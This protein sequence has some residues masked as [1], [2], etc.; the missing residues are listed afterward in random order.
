[1]SADQVAED[2]VLNHHRYLQ[3]QHAYGCKAVG[4]PVRPLTDE[5]EEAPW[6]DKYWEAT[7]EYAQKVVDSLQALINQSEQERTKH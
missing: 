5:D 7:S 1:M 6:Y 3:E 2:I 4:I